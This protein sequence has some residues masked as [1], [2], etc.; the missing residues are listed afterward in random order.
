[1]FRVAGER[2]DLVTAAVRAVIGEAC[3]A[4]G[5]VPWQRRW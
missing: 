3:S 4:L 5:A 2:V 1:V